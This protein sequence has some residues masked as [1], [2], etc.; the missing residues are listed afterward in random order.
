M[1]PGMNTLINKK[2]LEDILITI[3]KNNPK[4]ELNFCYV[5][6]ENIVSTNT[7]ALT[8][9]THG[10]KIDNHFFIERNLIEKATKEKN[11][12]YFKIA[13]SKITAY[14][15]DLNELITLSIEKPTNKDNYKYPEYERIIPKEFEKKISFVDYS[16]INGMFA[17]NKVDVNP[18]W[19]PK[20]KLGYIY[21]N[22]KNLPVMIENAEY[23][24]KTLIM[25]IIDRFKEFDENGYLDQ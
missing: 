7:R 14:D 17:I 24:I 8:V 3:D 21:I 11:A 5:D 10:L 20:T 22:N 9:A 23:K 18:I 15:K 19:I 1:Q 12:L 13:P 16:Q 4:W 6:K 25:P 2:L